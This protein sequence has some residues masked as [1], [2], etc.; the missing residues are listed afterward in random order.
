M[1]GVDQE[2]ARTFGNYILH[3]MQEVSLPAPVS[4]MPQTTAW[5]VLLIAL[6]LGLIVRVY[7]F[8]LKVWRNRYRKVALTRLKELEGLSDQSELLR[9][10][11]ALLKATSLQAFPREQVASLTGDSWLE[12]LSESN[13]KVSFQDSVGLLLVTQSYQNTTGAELKPNDLSLLIAKARVWIKAHQNPAD[14]RTRN[15]WLR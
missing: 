11:A 5:K 2:F 1:E 3:G 7:Y 8:G 14:V 12:F 9:E 6:C 13:A 15:G 4:W 10:L